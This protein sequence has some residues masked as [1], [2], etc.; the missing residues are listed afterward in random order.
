LSPEDRKNPPGGELSPAEGPA[1]RRVLW[2]SIGATAV[3]P[4]IYLLVWAF[5]LPPPTTGAL[6]KAIPEAGLNRLEQDSTARGGRSASPRDLVPDV[7]RAIW[8]GKEPQS[9]SI[10][11]GVDRAE[12]ETALREAFPRPPSSA[13]VVHGPVPGT[14]GLYTLEVT[15]HDGRK[16]LV[17][18]R[19][20][21][22]RD[23]RSA[24]EVESVVVIRPPR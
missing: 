10:S 18:L 17:G 20:I 23:P 15:D 14:P 22:S 12:M 6:E 3:L 2:I 13:Q 9:P 24:W 8:G 4:A 19:L 16:G 21:R 7:F 5:L 1:P 11:V